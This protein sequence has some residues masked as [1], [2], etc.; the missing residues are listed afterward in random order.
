MGDASA[1]KEGEEKDILR[2]D[3]VWYSSS[4]SE[5]CGLETTQTDKI[6]YKMLSP[7]VWT[8]G[9]RGFDSRRL[10]VSVEKPREGWWG[11]CSQN[12]GIV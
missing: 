7:G 2:Y 11:R 6:W 8:H 3:G 12:P 5:G 1:I 4:W 10:G 9:G